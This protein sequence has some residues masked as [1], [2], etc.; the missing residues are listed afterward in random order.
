MY[1]SALFVALIFAVG[2]FQKSK[3]EGK[4]SY[5]IWAF[6]IA[7]VAIVFGAFAIKAIIHIL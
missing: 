3:E 6:L 2:L 5:K 4:G 1:F 7:F